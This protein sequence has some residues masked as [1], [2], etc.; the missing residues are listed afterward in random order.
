M[1]RHECVSTHTHFSIILLVNWHWCRCHCEYF[2]RLPGS[3]CCRPHNTWRHLAA[4]ALFCLWIYFF[5]ALF[6]LPVVYIYIYIYNLN[7]LFAFKGFGAPQNSV[8]ELSCWLFLYSRCHRLT[9]FY[10]HDL[11]HFSFTQFQGHLSE[12]VIPST[13]KSKKK[14]ISREEMENLPISLC[15]SG[16]VFH[17]QLGGVNNSPVSWAGWLSNSDWTG[18]RFVPQFVYHAWKVSA[19][20]G[21]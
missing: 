4:S 2:A 16:V 10:W 1:F 17:N 21:A 7:F 8:S 18:Q 14:Q 6:F 20:A 5:L 19:V 13:E 12:P 9:K 15:I 11:I 3:W